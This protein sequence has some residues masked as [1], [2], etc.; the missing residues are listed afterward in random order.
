MWSFIHDFVRAIFD[1]LFYCMVVGLLFS[2]IFYRK[3]RGRLLLTLAVMLLFL[4]WRY[5]LNAVT[6]RYFGI[7]IVP[8]VLFS[9]ALCYCWI[10]PAWLSRLGAFAIF[11]ICFVQSVHFNTYAK[12]WI[13][14]CKL[15]NSDAAGSRARVINLLADGR[16]GQLEYYTDKNLTV[17]AYGLPR[18]SGN[19]MPVL[20]SFLVNSTESGECTYVIIRYD[21]SERDELLALVGRTAGLELL[22]NVP[23]ERREHDYLAV[24]RFRRPTGFGDLSSVAVAAEQ[25]EWRDSDIEEVL[26][27]KE[28]I[29]QQLKQMALPP[30][31]E[32][33]LP[34]YWAISIPAHDDP[35]GG[36]IRLIPGEGGYSLEFSAVPRRYMYNTQFLPAGDYVVSLSGSAAPGS[37]IGIAVTPWKSRSK[38]GRAVMVARYDIESAEPFSKE[39]F[40]PA[41]VANGEP[42]FRFGVFCENG[43][44]TL[45]RFEVR[46]VDADGI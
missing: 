32:V 4:A 21:V 23:S 40:I 8:A 35:G 38:A 13:N 31:S 5:M 19:A 10:F 36:E 22:S 25:P 1:P 15:V 39:I 16:Q 30:D 33:T 44:V 37:S 6:A 45:H 2:I 46:R 7:F 17:M 14:A 20:K 26:A 18:I 11:V 28:K 3:E 34:R 41:G 43:Q 9:V 29:E 42:E 12:Y 27:D 24:L